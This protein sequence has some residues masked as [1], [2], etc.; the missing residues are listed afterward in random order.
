M[1]KKKQY[2]KPKNSAKLKFKLEEDKSEIIEKAFSYICRDRVKELDKLIEKNKW[3]I[4]LK[5]PA[6]PFFY[7]TTLLA[8]SLEKAKIK[9]IKLLL[10]KGADPNERVYEE[11]PLIFFAK[12]LE[13]LKLLKEF[14]AN[15]NA[16]FKEKNLLYEELR[17]PIKRRHDWIKFLLENNV[18]IPDKIEGYPID[19]YIDKLNEK[20]KKLFKR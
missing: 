19:R 16:T 18:K 1:L 7:L 14:G 11:K 9:S 20:S 3:L 13:H 2:F 6:Y 12:T 5:I 4:K 10:E 17:N 8:Y 15:L